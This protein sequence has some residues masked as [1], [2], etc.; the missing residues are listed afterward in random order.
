MVIGTPAKIIKA[1]DETPLSE[2]Q[3]MSKPNANAGRIVD[4]YE[5]NAD[6]NV[7]SCKNKTM[8]TK[9]QLNTPNFSSN[10]LQVSFSGLF[11]TFVLK[12]NFNY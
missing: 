11:I 10:N 8:K 2:V 1:V 6:E 3:V 5:L 4:S 12:F 7:N 9:A